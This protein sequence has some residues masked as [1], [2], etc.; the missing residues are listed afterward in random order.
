MPFDRSARTVASVLCRGV[1]DLALHHLHTKC[2]DWYCSTFK[3]QFLELRHTLDDDACLGRGGEAAP[4]GVDQL[5]C[6]GVLEFQ[7][8]RLQIQLGLNF[9]ILDSRRVLVGT[10]STIGVGIKTKHISNQVLASC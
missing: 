6:C 3:R 1:F 5:D 10:T 8:T 4:D 9:F 2:T 7:H